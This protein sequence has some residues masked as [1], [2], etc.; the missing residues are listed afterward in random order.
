MLLGQHL[1]ELYFIIHSIK[2]AG[3]FHKTPKQLKLWLVRH[4]CIRTGDTLSYWGLASPLTHYFEYLWKMLLGLW[5][6]SGYMHK[7]DQFVACLCNMQHILLIWLCLFLYLF[8]PINRRWYKEAS[9][10]KWYISSSLTFRLNCK[11]C[12]HSTQ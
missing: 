6:S 3:A 10:N 4:L 1:T 2:T 12:W 5:S 8:G 9:Q 7:G 11:S